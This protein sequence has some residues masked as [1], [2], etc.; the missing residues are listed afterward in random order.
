MRYACVCV[1]VDSVACVAARVQCKGAKV[2][3]AGKCV[4]A[5]RGRQGVRMRGVCGKSVR[6]ACVRAVVRC[7][8][9][10][11]RVAGVW[12]VRSAVRA[13]RPVRRQ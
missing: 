6:V 1:C 3:Q 12:C 10:C 13:D 8:R 7:V 2:W 5:G 11:V 9:A 4:Y